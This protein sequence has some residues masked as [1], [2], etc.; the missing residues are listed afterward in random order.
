MKKPVEGYFVDL[1]YRIKIYPEEDGSGYTAMIPDLPGCMTC[2]DTI[3]E[4][5]DMI[6]EAKELWLEVALRDGD[7]IP[8]PSRAI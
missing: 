2:A 8:I 7:H 3:E 4:I 5:L 6:Q 1:S